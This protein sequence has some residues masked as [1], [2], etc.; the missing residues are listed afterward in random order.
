MPE[1]KRDFTPSVESVKGIHKS[2][3][4]EEIIPGASQKVPDFNSSIEQKRQ[5]IY[6]QYETGERVVINGPNKPWDGKSKRK[7][8]HFASVF[9]R[10]E[11]TGKKLNVMKDE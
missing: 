10:M 7:A 2:A 11:A 1:D 9:R 8:G 5:M 3:E 6:S 4:Q